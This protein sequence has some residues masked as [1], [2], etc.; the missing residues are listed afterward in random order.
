MSGFA[1]VGLLLAVVGVY[2]LTAFDVRRRFRE[3]GIRVSLGAE[4]GRIPAMILGQRMRATAV[5]IV[6]GLA[7]ASLVVRA[8]ENQLYGVTSS[9]PF[10]WAA[11]TVVV[12]VAS[13]LATY[14]PA[15]RATRVD[16]R[17]V[18]ASDG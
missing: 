10:T 3:I 5:G 14:L 12:V 1:L 13:A 15:R 6:V 2:G 9:D 16:A 4:P 17:E 8:L 18:L 7:A 11:V